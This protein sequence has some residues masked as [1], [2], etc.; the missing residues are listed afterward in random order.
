MFPSDISTIYNLCL[1]AR[2][3]PKK[4]E[5]TYS[6]V[7]ELHARPGFLKFDIVAFIKAQLPNDK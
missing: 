7:T 3:P 4:W 5:V 1:N 2:I 6:A